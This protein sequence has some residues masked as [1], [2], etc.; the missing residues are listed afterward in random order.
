MPAAEVFRLIVDNADAPA[1]EALILTRGARQSDY[2]HPLDD[3]GDTAA[4]WTVMLRR[5]LLEPITAED[6]ALCMVQVKMA[7]QCHRP[8]R[9][10]IVDGIGYLETAHMVGVERARRTG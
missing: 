9:D 1:L 10:N 4:L 5:K 6:V 2:G 8:K 7:R 3:F